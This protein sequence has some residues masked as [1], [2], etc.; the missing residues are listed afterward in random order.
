MAWMKE[1]EALTK[2]PE[3]L[4]QGRFSFTFDGVPL[5]AE[6]LSFQKRMNLFRTGID[7][8]LGSSYSHALPPTVQMPQ[9][10]EKAFTMVEIVLIIAVIVLIRIAFKIVQFFRVKNYYLFELRSKT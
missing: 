4:I 5:V 9:K 6:R 8:M 1:S 7:M 3:L 2:L 10:S